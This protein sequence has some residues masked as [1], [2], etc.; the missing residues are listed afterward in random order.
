MRAFSILLLLLSYSLNV[1]SEFIP[2]PDEVCLGDSITYHCELTG[3]FTAVQLFIV[4]SVSF[5]FIQINLDTAIGYNLSR[6]SA[7]V[8]NTLNPSDGIYSALRANITLVNINKGDNN[9]LMGCK[10]PISGTNDI[11]EKSDNL[12]L[13][14]PPSKPSIRVVPI[15]SNCTVK[16]H[17]FHHSTQLLTQHLSDSASNRLSLTSDRTYFSSPLSAGEEISYTLSAEYCLGDGTVSTTPFTP[18]SQPDSF[19][20]SAT[21]GTEDSRLVI[22]ISDYTS[23]YSIET[24]FD[25]FTES[26]SV[27]SGDFSENSPLYYSKEMFDLQTTSN[28]TVRLSSVLRD[29][30]GSDSLMCEVKLNVTLKAPITTTIA[31][32]M[33]TP[34]MT[35]HQPQPSPLPTYVTYIIIAVVL[36]FVLL[37]LSLVIFVLAFLIHRSK[38]ARYKSFPK[39]RLPEPPLEKDINGEELHYM[40]PDFSQTQDAPR[41]KPPYAPTQY[42]DLNQASLAMHEHN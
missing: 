26:G 27:L 25:L 30:I 23:E 7:T 32:S 12:R 6:F 17:W 41:P 11:Q 38:I 9:T 22:Q 35:P 20:C 33:N 4:N 21:Y 3:A 1:S 8:D 10:A 19:D 24:S 31:T 2:P 13:A 36:F 5:N 18:P 28:Y 40:Q 15:P 42:A 34:S 37:L 14:S 39:K 16:V 29:C